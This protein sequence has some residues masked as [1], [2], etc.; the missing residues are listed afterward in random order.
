[1]RRC[2]HF[3]IFCFLII[4]LVGCEDRLDL[5]KQSISLIYGF[6]AKPKRKINCVSRKPY[7]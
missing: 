7:F 2:I 1:M 3:I 4:F 6:D 5:E